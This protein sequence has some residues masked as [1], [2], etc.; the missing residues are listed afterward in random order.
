MKKETQTEIE[1]YMKEA[2]ETETKIKA[3]ITA[4][5]E[6]DSKTY[7]GTSEYGNRDGLKVYLESLDKTEIWDEFFALVHSRHGF[8]NPKSKLGNFTRKYGTY[9]KEG[10]EVEAE[11]D[12]N[13][14]FKVVC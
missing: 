7:F 13:G 1:K 9:P 4:I 11:V 2:E 12:E 3:K 5:E 6:I 14:F 8:S 10:L